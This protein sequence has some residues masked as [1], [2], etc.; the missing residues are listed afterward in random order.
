MERGTE[1]GTEGGR[2]ARCDGLTRLE[3]HRIVLDHEHS[4]FRGI[5][6]IAGA[7][8]AAPS[9]RRGPLP[10]A[11]VLPLRHEGD[12][13]EPTISEKTTRTAAFYFNVC[14][15]PALRAA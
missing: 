4:Q 14:F 8:R 13:V 10:D 15:R 12:R 3:A 11:L 2:S 9:L 5:E 1:G 6:A 7:F